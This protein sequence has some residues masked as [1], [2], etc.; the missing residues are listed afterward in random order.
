[1]EVGRQTTRASKRK[2][3]GHFSGPSDARKLQYRSVGYFPDKTNTYY[4]C[5]VHFPQSVLGWRYISVTGTTIATI[6]LVL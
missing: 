4:K 2:L 6:F 3:I 1:M 5:A